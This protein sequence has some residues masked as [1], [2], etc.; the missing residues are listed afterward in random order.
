MNKVWKEIKGYEGLY[1]I[2]NLGRVKSL[3]RYKKAKGEGKTLLP[4][5]IMKVQ[6]AR[7]GYKTLPLCKNCI[8]KYHTVHRIVALSFLPN[9]QNKRCV[10]HKDG[11]KLNNNVN[12]LYWGSYKENLEDQKKHG[13]F[14]CGEISY[15]HKLNEKQVRVIKHILNIPNHISYRQIGE[16]F[17]VSEFAIFDIKRGK[18]WKHVKI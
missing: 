16:I 14:I 12:N 10:C 5:K 1:E 13:T 15:L 7:N 3:E 17:K 2:S 8:Y 18:S 4:E 11:N 9:L 6:V